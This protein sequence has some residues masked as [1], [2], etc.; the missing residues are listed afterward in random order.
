VAAGAVIATLVIAALAAGAILAL[1]SG[2][3]MPFSAQGARATSQKPAPGPTDLN[4]VPLSYWPDACRLVSTQEV[5]QTFGNAEFLPPQPGSGRMGNF[6]LPL[7]TACE[8]QS[9]DYQLGATVDVRVIS[10]SRTVAD[11]ARLFVSGRNVGD[12]APTALTGLGQQAAWYGGTTTEVRVQQRRVVYQLEVTLAG[13][14]TAGLPDRAQ[15]Q[16]SAAE[17]LARIAAG[18]IP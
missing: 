13:S 5:S 14:Q 17:A 8:H 18:R 15:R 3:A 2:A 1:R 10:V 9:T 12:T 16:L 4:G 6:T 11:A 7:P